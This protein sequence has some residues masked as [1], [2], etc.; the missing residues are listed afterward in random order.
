MASPTTN[1]SDEQR[2]RYERER[3][4]A[5]IRSI[6]ETKSN[7]R[8]AI[9]EAR[10]E[11][12]RYSQIITDL[13]NEI[14]DAAQ[15]TSD[16]FLESQKAIVNSIQ[17]AWTDIADRMRL[18]QPYYYWWTRGLVSPS[19][20][21]DV[22]ART[23]SSTTENFAAGARIATNIIFAGMESARANTRYARE[24]AKEMSRI[25]FN[26]ARAIGKTR[27]TVTVQ[28]ESSPVNIKVAE[29]DTATA[30]EGQTKGEA[31]S[32]KRKQEKEEGKK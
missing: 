9:E 8:R 2:N 24:N 21:V 6:D 20:M 5:T 19:D 1:P 23:I 3:R 18:M 30:E 7:I 4:E 15:E 31:T 32:S 28:G 29:T 16:A 10:R 13:Q 25:T 27:E 14:T 12:P 26:T 17:S 22:Y 11:M